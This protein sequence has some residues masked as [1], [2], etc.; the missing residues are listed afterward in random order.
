[1]KYRLLIPVL[2]VLT[3]ACSTKKHHEGGGEWKELNS[4]HK[5]MAEAFHPL[6]D[7]GSVVPAKKLATQLADEA[8]RWAASSL[9]EKV[10]NEEMKS[11][12][13]KL[14][15]DTRS[16]A[17]EISKGASDDVIKTK[18]TSLHDQFHKIME[19]WEGGH[20]EEGHGEDEE[21]EEHDEDED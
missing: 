18:L 3:S 5:I 13:Q 1:M 6:K 8:D 10:N 2:A 4:F 21:H 20:H 9:P 12:L 17:D 11:N 16:L 7:S 19:A 15:T 14:K